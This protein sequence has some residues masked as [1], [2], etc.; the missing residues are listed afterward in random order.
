M[1]LPLPVT[2]NCRLKAHSHT[3]RQRALSCGMTRHDAACCVEN[4]AEIKPVLIS[5]SR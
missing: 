5:P 1:K 3:V 2:A 4:A